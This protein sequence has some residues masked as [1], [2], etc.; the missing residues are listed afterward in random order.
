V[1][2]FHSRSHA[3]RVVLASPNLAGCWSD[4]QDFDDRAGLKMHGQMAA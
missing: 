2:I 1:A 4:W 3:A